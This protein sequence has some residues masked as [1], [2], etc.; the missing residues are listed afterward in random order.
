MRT[1]RSFLALKLDLSVVESIAEAQKRLRTSCSNAG[2]N[3]RWVPPPNIH[4]TIRFLGNITEPMAY[5][6]KDMLEPIVSGV[7]SFDLES[8]GL[9]AFP[10]TS[11]PR[12]VWAG[13]GQGVEVLTELHSAIYNRLLKAGFNLDDKPFKAH[14]TIGR[15]K[16]SPPGAFANCLGEDASRVF[17]VS[18]IRYLHCYSSELLPKGAEYRSVWVLP[19]SQNNNRRAAQRN[20]GLQT[21]PSSQIPTNNDKEEESR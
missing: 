11:H 6:V 14:L 9:G 4:M 5:A 13:L 7:E 18:H 20:S 8:L 1:I 2:M 12:I 19:F 16:N 15:V 3:V 10:D 17:G 21:A